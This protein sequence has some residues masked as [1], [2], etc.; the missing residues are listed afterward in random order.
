MT[1]PSVA[2][3]KVIELGYELLP[4]LLYSPDLARTT[5]SYLQTWKN[6]LPEDWVE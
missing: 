2:I 6:H 3:S 4:Y 5:S 1:N